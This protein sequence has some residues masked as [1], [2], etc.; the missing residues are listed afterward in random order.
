MHRSSLEQPV[1]VHTKCESLPGVSRLAER[2]AKIDSYRD[3]GKQFESS[4]FSGV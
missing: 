1:Q 2:A 3:T 4:A